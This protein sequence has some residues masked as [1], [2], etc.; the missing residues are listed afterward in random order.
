MMHPSGASPARGLPLAAAMCASHASGPVGWRCAAALLR[1]VM[2]ALLPLSADEAYYWLWSQHLAAGYFDHPPMIA[3]LIRAGTLA[4]RRH[5]VGRAPVGRGAVAARHL[6][7]LARAAL[8]LKDEDRAALAALFFNLTLMVSVELLAATPDMPSIVTAPPLSIAWR[9]CRRRGNG[10]WWL[11]RGHR[12]R[13]GPAVQILRS[14]SGRGR[15]GLADRGS[16]CAQMAA[17]ALAVS[18]RASWRWRSS[19]PIWC[20]SRSITGRP[21]PSSSA[22]SAPAISPCAFWANS[23]RRNSAWPRR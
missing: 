10:K 6:V 14:V 20:G 12:R 7:C 3:W 1:G 21:S 9:R 16:R 15:A 5:A 8:I 13:S 18:G 23:W 19:R 11:A 4:V 2:A 17:Y 22:A